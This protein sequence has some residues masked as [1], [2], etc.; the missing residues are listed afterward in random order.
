MCKHKARGVRRFLDKKDA[1]STGNMRKHARKCWGDDVVISA[2][3]AETADEVR[4]TT[5]TGILNPQSITVAFE[6]KGKGK[7]TY[8]HRQHTR[9]ESRHVNGVQDISW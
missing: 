8:F 6:W 2:D 3:K 7:V 4:S 9:A 1:K 5:A